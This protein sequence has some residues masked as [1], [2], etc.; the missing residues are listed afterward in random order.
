MTLSSRPAPTENEKVKP[1]EIPSRSLFLNGT[2]TQFFNKQKMANTV[3]AEDALNKLMEGNAR[4]VKGE[5]QHPRMDLARRAELKEG[6][7]PFAVIVACADSRV[8]PE[9]IFDEGLGDIF[10][11]RV[12]GNVAKEKVIGSI[13]YAT[14][15]LGVNLVMVLGHE[16][17]GAVSASIGTTEFE[18][19]IGTIVDAIKPAVYMAEAMEGDLLTNAIQNNAKIT[20]GHIKEA[21][22]VM[23]RLVKERVKVV[24]AYYSIDTGAVTLL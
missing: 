18:G 24:S 23:T 13:E 15:H 4:F 14:A 8:A 21:H 9:I 3:S 7:E 6:Q 1:V 2:L 16:K 17:C 5:L 12:A 22:P 20:A 11:I 19:N 10:V